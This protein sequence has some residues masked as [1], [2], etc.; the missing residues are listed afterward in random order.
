LVQLH[1]QEETI[2]ISIS[3]KLEKEYKNQMKQQSDA[4]LKEAIALQE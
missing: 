4:K 2:Y 1:H 3:V